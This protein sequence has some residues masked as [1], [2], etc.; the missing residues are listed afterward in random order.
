MFQYAFLYAQMRE[1]R[2]PDVYVQSHRFFEKYT[3]EI[4]ALFG[5]GIGFLEQVG[6]HVRRGDYVGNP[7]HVNLSQTDYY[8][9]AMKR[10][11][12]K[13]F[14]VFSDDP[15]WCKEHMI[16]DNIQVM[17]GGT[18]I[19]DFNMLASCSSVIMANS[20]FS[21]WAAYLNPTPTKKIIL[22]RLDKWFHDGLVRVEVPDQWE[23]MDYA[24]K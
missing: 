14:L 1:G 5:E 6:I 22:P 4:K 17:E 8:D 23:Q 16:G 19:E 11:P 20:S 9:R 2:I 12:Q 3:D 10:F 7:L 24:A 13:N 15:V 21:W 18:E